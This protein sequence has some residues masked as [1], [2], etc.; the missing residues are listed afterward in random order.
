MAEPGELVE[1][2]GL[3]ALDPALLQLALTHRSYYNER[4]QAAEG[5]NERLEFLGDAVLG[6]VIA[7]ELYRRL[8]TLSEGELTSL[9]AALVRRETLAQA[10]RRLT[11]GRALLLG[12]GEEAGGGRERDQ[13]LASAFE[14]LVGAVYLACGLEE[15]RQFILRQLGEEI[16]SQ[17]AAGPQKDEKSRLQELAQA[18]WQL[19]PVYCTVAATGP[20][21]AKEF[22]VQVRIGNRIAGEG[23][24]RTKQAA[25]QLAA[26]QALA[27][28]ESLPLT[29]PLPADWPAAPPSEPC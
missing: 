18:R 9:R 13:I 7:E 2:L 17:V 11:L 23:V 14:A 20:D 25:E 27:T 4:P 3:P 28:L 24:G 29:A 21:H 15:C 6:L 10:A 19:T 5:T 26:R 22:R 1:R 8:P 12:R 16:A